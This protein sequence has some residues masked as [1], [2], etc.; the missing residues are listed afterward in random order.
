MCLGIAFV[1]LPTVWLMVIASTVLSIGYCLSAPTAV[2]I[3]SVGMNNIVEMVS[4]NMN[5]SYYSQTSTHPDFQGKILSYNNFFSQAAQIISPIALSG[6]Y[7]VNQELVF[8]I[9]AGISAISLVAILY[10]RTWKNAK[11]I[12]KVALYK[13]NREEKEKEV[14]LTKVVTDKPVVVE[15][16]KSEEAKEVKAEPIITVSI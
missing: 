13:Q 6:I 16:E 14:E 8:Y 2:T 11:D 15:M 1:T 7:E 3:L 10:V 4:T 12:G 9:T 5:K